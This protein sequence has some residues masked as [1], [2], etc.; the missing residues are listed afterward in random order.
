MNARFK[1]PAGIAVVAVGF[2]SLGYGL[3][4]LL[5][6]LD[7]FSIE[8]AGPA[9]VM[10]FLQTNAD[11]LEL[12]LMSAM[13]GYLLAVPMMLL[14][15]SAAFHG[16]T[17]LPLGR[18]VAVGL[19]WAS[20]PLRPLWWAAM[21]VLMPRMSALSITSTEPAT[22]S[23][24]IVGYQMLYTVLNTATEDIAINLLGGSWFV[25]IGYVMT[26]SPGLSRIL[27]TIGMVIGT[28]YLLSSAE[29]FGLPMGGSGEVIP[30]I[31]GVAGP[32]WLGAAGIFAVRKMT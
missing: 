12:A 27:G 30:L 4:T 28:C 29:L 8:T 25:I 16:K 22:L 2:L 23:A 11:T 1:R 17:V 9:D 20:L 32:F 26:T 18:D 21:I 19:V 31:A 3:T 10:G 14:I 6:G 5:V 24:T 13:V 7:F 15:T